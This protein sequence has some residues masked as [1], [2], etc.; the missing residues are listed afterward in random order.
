MIQ[1]PIPYADDNPTPGK[2]K[3]VL[4]LIAINA[5]IFIILP[6]SLYPLFA[7][8]PTLP[9]K[10]VTP[11]SSM[12]LH[13]S[14]MHLAGNMWFLWLFGPR[15]E[16]AMGWRFLGFY[17]IG[18]AMAD[19]A[20]LFSSPSDD[21]MAIGASGA[22]YAVIGAYCVLFPDA[23]LRCASWFL[24]Y[25]PYLC[26]LPAPVF[27]LLYCGMDYMSMQASGGEGVVA[28]AAHLGGAAFGV[29]VAFAIKEPEAPKEGAWSSDMMRR[30]AAYDSGAAGKRIL[31]A[32]SAGSVADAVNEYVVASR[33]D[34]E[35]QLEGDPQLRIAEK[36]VGARQPQLAR[37]ALEKYILRNPVSPLC[38]NAYLLMGYVEQAQLGNFASAAGAYQSALRHP[39]APEGEVEDAQKRLAAIQAVTKRHFVEPEAE[40]DVY[41]L[42]LGD[43]TILSGTQLGAIARMLKWPEE[44]LRA[45]LD[46]SPGVLVGDLN[47]AQAD[48]LAKECA[49]LGLHMVALPARSFFPV[50]A[51]GMVRTL[52]LDAAGA[53][54]TDEQDSVARMAWNDC[55]LISAAG[56]RIGEGVL[57]VLELV[58][59][60]GARFRWSASADLTP[61]PEGDERFF[62]ALQDAVLLAQ[63]VPRDTG[64]LSAFDRR[65]PETS[66]RDCFEDLDGPLSWQLQ[67]ARLKK[68]GAWA[69]LI[70]APPQRA[71]E[72]PTAVHE[73]VS[74][75]PA[76]GAVP[77]TAQA[78][79]APGPAGA[80]GVSWL[81]LVLGWL[82][83]F[84]G[85]IVSWFG[86][87]I[88]SMLI[89][90]LSA[91]KPGMSAEAARAAVKQL[92]AA[93]EA[94]FIHN[95]ASF[96]IALL[97]IAAAG[98]LAARLARGAERR[99]AWI[100]GALNMPTSLL[101]GV[102]V[103]MSSTEP[104]I[105]D[106]LSVLTI[107][108]TIPA[109]LVGASLAERRTQGPFSGLSPRGPEG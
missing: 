106:V 86:M 104:V 35:F 38:A 67:L 30:R 23:R 59:T 74:A 103:W 95:F 14:F 11:F 25:R 102:M 58:T 89:A 13:G 46:R 63:G 29:A 98:Y 17:L 99:H 96:V 19:V 76:P 61:S 33:N 77:E 60:Q 53:A 75:E 100:V 65:L 64:A 68:A 66:I 109:A 93:V 22:V 7:F 79:S 48:W 52:A 12:F 62:N 91:R 4:S 82:V 44:T 37:A 72:S 71:E 1:P 16:A 85:R 90:S 18:G 43:A 9:T 45:S 55:L 49:A 8:I 41:W 73:A 2:N 40:G 20:F 28:Y 108:A 105:A 87:G 92:D 94:S 88:V 21:F 101:A 6:E 69:S 81:A 42:L 24:Y 27:G 51:A 78:G 80:A 97:W 83:P 84:V 47:R 3:I 36:L 32:L 15:V 70:Q 56:V 26:T 107:L 10:W 57:P 5:L 39:S 54:L 50:P 34:P 31:E